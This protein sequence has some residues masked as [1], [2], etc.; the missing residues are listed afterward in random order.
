[1]LTIFISHWNT[2]SFCNIPLELAEQFE[3]IGWCAALIA[4]LPAIPVKI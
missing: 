1:V 3:T 2:I 4:L